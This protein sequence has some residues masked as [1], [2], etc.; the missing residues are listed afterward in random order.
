M[1]CNIIS[2]CGNDALMFHNPFLVRIPYS[3]QLHKEPNKSEHWNTT[4]KH[5]NLAESGGKIREVNK[6]RKGDENCVEKL[7]KQPNFFSRAGKVRSVFF[8][9]KPMI[10][11]VCK[12]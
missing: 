1:S 2:K 9:N 8:T 5:P 6:V 3:F 10:L 12:E 4:K 7:K 11:V